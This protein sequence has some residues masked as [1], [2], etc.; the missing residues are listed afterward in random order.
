MVFMNHLGVVR[1]SQV[2]SVAITILISDNEI[3]WLLGVPAEGR[4]FILEVDFVQW[5]VA[6]GVIKAYAPIKCGTREQIN[7]TRIEFNS[8]Y[9]IHSPLESLERLR[10][11]IVPN[12]YNCSA[13][14]EHIF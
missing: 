12:L 4:R 14:R 1:L 2:K 6:S 8:G 5:C 7:L 10:P 9:G 3:H 11:L 13:C